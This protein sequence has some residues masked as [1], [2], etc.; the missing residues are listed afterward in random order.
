MTQ[1]KIFC[2][3]VTYRPNAEHLRRVLASITLQTPHVI[4]VD[5]TPAPH[6]FGTI[7]TG[8]QCIT[9]GNNVGIAAAQNIGISLA[10]KQGADIIWL[11]DQDTV[12]PHNFLTDMRAALKACQ[13]QGIRLGALAPSYFDTHKG[14]VQPFPTH[15]PFTRL[16]EPTRGLQRVA[17]AIASGSLIPATVLHEVGLMQENLFIDWVDMEWC[18]RA[19]NKHGYQIVCTG[20]VMVEH[21]MGDGSI[22]FLWRKVGLRTPLRRYYMVRNAIHIALYS[23]SATIAIRLEIFARA[24]YWTVAFPLISP[25]NK[26]QHLRAT[27][28]G[29]WDG[30]R[31]R[32]GEK[33]L[34]SPI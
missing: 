18:W 34:N 28:S 1:C 33:T 4:L 17:H 23:R 31:N 21:T 9:L 2:V 12:Y 16:R 6:D 11:S 24:F 3:I 30:L 27:L 8:G 29:L 25:V 32:M 14:A 10:L 19:H 7:L 5:N 13:I 22:R 26:V 15:T 20:D